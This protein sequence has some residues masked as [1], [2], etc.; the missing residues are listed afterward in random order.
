[1]S[2]VVVRAVLGQFSPRRRW[3]SALNI[4]PP[5]DHP[6]LHLH[7]RITEEQR[8][9]AWEPSKIEFFFGNYGRGHQCEKRVHFLFVLKGYSFD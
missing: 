8:N 6:N 2:F 3:F 7:V 4:S 5:T 1:M 9:K